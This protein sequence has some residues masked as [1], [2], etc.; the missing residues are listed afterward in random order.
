[1]TSPASDLDIDQ[2]AATVR[3]EPTGANFVR[4]WRAVFGLESWLLLPTGDAADPR[5]MIGLVEDQSFL[6]AFTSE[7]R[8]K[9]FAVSRTSG[10]PDGHGIAAMSITPSALTDLAPGLIQQGIAGVLFD[11]GSSSFVAPISGLRSLRDQFGSHPGAD[12]AAEPAE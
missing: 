11:Q 6:L 7:L 12:A 10:P 9:E 1:M 3:D 2:L 4:L 8:L 5:P